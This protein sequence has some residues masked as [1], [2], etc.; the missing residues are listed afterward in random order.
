MAHP[1]FQNLSSV[2]RPLALQA[3][4]DIRSS[5][6]A[7][8]GQ[9]GQVLKDPLTLE[10]FHLTAEEYFLFDFLGETTSLSQLR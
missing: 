3:R 6:V 7:F 10:L 2:D 8:S 9:S 1:H 4:A 5:S